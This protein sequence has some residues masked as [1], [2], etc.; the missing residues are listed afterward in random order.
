MLCL[1]TAGRNM[2]FSGSTDK[3]I[4]VWMRV[5]VVHTS[6]SVLSGHTGSMK[7][8]TVEEDKESTYRGNQK[9]RQICNISNEVVDAISKEVLSFHSEVVYLTNHLAKTSNWLKR[10]A[11]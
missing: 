9:W 6:L 10:Q 7:C 3:T 8:L 4:C 11:I 1:A 5:V 2:M